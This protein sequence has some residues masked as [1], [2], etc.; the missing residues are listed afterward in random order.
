MSVNLRTS[1]LIDS[2]NNENQFGTILFTGPVNECDLIDFELKMIDVLC[3]L[4]EGIGKFEK[5]QLKFEF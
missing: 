2:T 3:I 1:K 5:Y 4:H